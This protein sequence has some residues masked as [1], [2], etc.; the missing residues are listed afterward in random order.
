VVYGDRAFPYRVV[1]ELRR[2]EPAVAPEQALQETLTV[3]SRSLRLSYASVESGGASSDDRFV[4][5]L[6]ERRG[7][8]T[9]VELEVA[10]QPLGRLEMEVSPLRD[11]FGPRDRR[12]LEDIGTQVGALVQAL[13][14]NRE[15]RRTR[16]RLVEAREE[17]RRRL[18]RDLHDGIGP[19]LATM[20]MRLEVAK[21]LVARDPAEATELIGQLTDQ[22]EADIGEIRRL[23]DGL[24]PPALD[25]LGLV[26]ALRQRAD[27]H[28]RAAT[29]GSASSLTWSVAADDL[30]ALPAA[31]EVAA[32]RI[33]VEAV[34]NAVRHSGGSAC[35]VTLRRESGALALEIRDDGIGLPDVRRSGV[36]IGSMRERAEELG[37]TC[38]VTPAPDRG[39][40]VVVHLPLATDEDPAA[41]REE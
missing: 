33:A 21:D 16:Q 7:E 36:G 2:L 27:V 15:L 38:T 34:S 8:P 14:A 41:T 10:G 37:G 39:T 20:L 31:V 26:S 40:L 5:A 3:L 25:Q 17:E 6:G 30:G 24:R 19:S 11:P 1:S 13:A 12:L 28:N 22:T 18:R 32:Y 23:V 4:I 9:T 35:V 29:L